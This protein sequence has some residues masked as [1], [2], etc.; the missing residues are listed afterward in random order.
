VV[1]RF[2]PAIT[3][4]EG[5]LVAIDID[6][7]PFDNSQT[8]K[9]GVAWTYKKFIGYAPIFAYVGQ[10]GY[11]AN[12][13]LRP[14]SDHC[15]RGTTQFLERTL[16]YARMMSDAPFLVRMD[17]G[18]DSLDN[19]QVCRREKAAYLIKR[20]LRKESKEEWLRIAMTCGEMEKA[21][22]GEEVWRGEHYVRR[23]DIDDPLRIVFCVSR[24]TV[25]A[26][27]QALLVPEVE[28]ETYWTSLDADAARVIE[29]YHAHGTSEQFHSELKTD[30]DLERLPSGK[31]QTNELVLLLGMIAYNLLRLIGQESLRENDTPVRKRVSRRRLRS[32]MQDMIYLACRMVRHARQWKLSFGRH[33]PWFSAW[34]RVYLRVALA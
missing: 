17:S 6:V 29:L 16:D 25:Q 23:T 14:G 2:A 30:L 18:N 9:E 15:Q 5:D 10:E 7:S 34:R 31:F 13:E 1:R 12:L 28:V 3:P 8:K 24:R 21:R 4:G 33:C 26:N 19:I 32:V 11:L 27:G 22:P 20:N